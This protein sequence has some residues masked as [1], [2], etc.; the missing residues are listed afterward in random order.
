MHGRALLCVF[1]NHKYH[2]SELWNYLKSDF[3]EIKSHDKLLFRKTSAN[4]ELHLWI[5]HEV[6]PILNKGGMIFRLSFLVCCVHE[7]MV[8]GGKSMKKFSFFCC[9][10]RENSL[11]KEKLVLAKKKKVFLS[12]HFL[13]HFHSHTPFYSLAI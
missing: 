11:P 8:W 4:I 1:L 10:I 13:S 3:F 12:G 2:Y 9:Y 7:K 6:L 5:I